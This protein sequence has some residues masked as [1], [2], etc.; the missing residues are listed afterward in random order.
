MIKNFNPTENQGSKFLGLQS[1][2]IRNKDRKNSF[3]GGVP[4]PK[5]PKN[6]EVFPKNVEPSPKNVEIHKKV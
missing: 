5:I 3:T 1:T 6:V 2:Y 4:R